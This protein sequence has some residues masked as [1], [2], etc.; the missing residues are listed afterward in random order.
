MRKKALDYLEYEKLK[1]VCLGVTMKSHYQV[2]AK[3]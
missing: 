3:Q 1:L 2:L